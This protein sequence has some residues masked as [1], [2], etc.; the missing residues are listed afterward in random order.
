MQ[1][2]HPTTAPL[3]LLVRRWPER[4][5]LLLGAAAALFVVI[6][7]SMAIVD[8]AAQG[9]GFLAVVPIVIVALEL[10]ERGGLAAGL[11]SLAVVLGAALMGR[12]DMGAV[13]I[14]MRGC[15]FVAVGVAAGH[16]S[17]RM[18]S[19][20]AREERLLR[21]GLRLSDVS[22]PERLC[23][24]LA[25]EVLA[26]PG[27]QAVEVHIDGVTH[28]HGRGGG[29]IH[30]L[31]PM[32]SHGIQVGRIDAVHQ[33]PL[34]PEDRAAL[35]LLARQAALA[36]ENLRLL[37]LDGERAALEL[38]L[39][40]VRRELVESRSGAGLLLQAEEEEKRRLADKLHEELAQVLAAVLMGMRVL[41][42]QSPDGRSAPLQALHEQVAQVL[43]D[44]R[45][46]ARE[47]RP[48]VLAQLGLRA[49]IEALARAARENGAHVSLDV[50]SVPRDLPE[51]VET[52]VY[53][54][55]EDAFAS[56]GGERLDVSIEP[57]AIGLQVELTM[58][59]P[60]PAVLLALRARAESLGG[61][62]EILP[63]DGADV[64]LLRATLP[65][66]VRTS[67][68]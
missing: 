25:R 37:G 6:F 13:A 2:I 53:R 26:T 36:A 14:A 21:S 19:T 33:V 11:L 8:D 39:R 62:S 35:E 68:R 29:E 24:D 40:E 60:E 10:G 50:Q 59:R 63:A 30:T 64:M 22:L 23:H 56:T 27:V 55:V 49:A 34:A 7:A 45:D 66:A 4:R 46:V 1:S 44:V 61:A 52:A 65:V 57:A 48:V 67:T 32:L 42:R 9:I 41:E 18:R 3:G 20:H 51:Q 43:A 58:R 38:R 16:F 17:D 28:A 54:L 47:L 5:P 15:V 31:V 12:P